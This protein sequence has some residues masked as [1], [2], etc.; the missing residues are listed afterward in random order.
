MNLQSNAL[1]AMD[2]SDTPQIDISFEAVSDARLRIIVADR[3]AGISDDAIGQLFDPFF[4]TKETGYGLGLG[5]SI[6]FNIIE[7]FGGR[8]S[9]ASR[10]DGGAEFIVELDRATAEVVA[11]GL[12]A[13]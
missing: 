10:K 6:S 7:D 1:D 5:L 8:L 3:G 2:L 9:A 13:E 12:A 11:K 4:T